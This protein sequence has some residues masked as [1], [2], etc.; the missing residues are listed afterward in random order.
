M[1]VLCLFGAHQYGNFSRGE[2]TES[3]SF[4]PALRALGHEIRIFDSWDKSVYSDYA[5]LNAA[6]VDA[7]KSDTP[8]IILWVA[9]TVE[10]WIETLD[11][12]RHDLGI[13]IIHW[14]PDD[15]WK[16]RQHSRFIA[17]HV[18]LCVTTYP[19]F[20]PIYRNVGAKAILSGWGVPEAWRGDVVSASK[21][22]YDVTFVG[23]AQPARAA[24][25]AALAG[26]GIYVQCFGFGWP[27]GPIASDKIPDI[28]RQSRISLNFSGSSGENQVKA[29]VFEVTGAGGFLLTETAPGL[30][31]MFEFDREIAVFASVDDCV[32]LVRHYLESPTH[33]DLVARAGNIRTQREYTYVVRLR[34]VLS[35]LPSVQPTPIVRRGRFDDVLLRHTHPQ[36][37]RLLATLLTQ[38]GIIIFGPQRGPRF[39]RR[40]CFELSW[41]IAGKFTYRAAG[42]VGRMFYEQ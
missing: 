28:F 41:R 40:L 27:S 38:L 34:Q 8:D 42:L 20:I 31:R 30:D 6:L 23:A 16:F 19:E 10:I 26:H 33:R 17:R 9:L 1:R 36:V 3:F 35:A 37:L 4:I 39:A 15:S 11:F 2:S 18:D 22:I 24:M 32:R 7:C 12:L 21:C 13:Q 29:R 5:E 25:V 14:A